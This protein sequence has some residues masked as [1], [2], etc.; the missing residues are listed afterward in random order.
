MDPS[1]GSTWKSIFRRYER[2]LKNLSDHCPPSTQPYP[3]WL[4]VKTIHTHQSHWVLWI[5]TPPPTTSPIRGFHLL[6]LQQSLWQVRSSYHSRKTSSVRDSRKAL[7][8]DIIVPHKT[9]A[10]GCGPGQHVLARLVP[11][12]SATR[13]GARTPPLP[14]PYARHHQINQPF[15]A[16]FLRRWH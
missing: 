13:I 5:N 3:T 11:L 2:L 1:L 9:S 10:S 7:R 15:P 12:W 8:M 16:L 14:Y 6:R 4:Y